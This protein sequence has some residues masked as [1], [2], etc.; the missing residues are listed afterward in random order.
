[1]NGQK[2]VFTVDAKGAVKIDAQGF[3]DST[4][5]TATAAFEAALGGPVESRIEKAEFFLAPT[6]D[7]AQEL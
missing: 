4:C 1:M 2:I 7:Q 3:A 5:A 6:N